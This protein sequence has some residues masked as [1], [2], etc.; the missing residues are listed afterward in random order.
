MSGLAKSFGDHQ[1]LT[2]IDFE[3]HAGSVT[4]P[5]GLSGSGKTTVLRL[6]N[7]LEILDRR[8]RAHRRGRPRLLTVG[9]QGRHRGPARPERDGLPVAQPLPPHDGPGEHHR[10]ARRSC[11]AG[12]GGDVV[13]DARRL[14]E[15]VG[16]E[17]KADQYL[18]QLS[19]GQQQRV[20]IAR[21]LALRPKF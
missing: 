14:L 11:S 21:A 8:A 13:S 6:L 2:S 17:E 15:L 9:R 18:Y 19:G 10:G 16:L 7:S 1:V 3:V 4:V 5:I 12:P 20:G